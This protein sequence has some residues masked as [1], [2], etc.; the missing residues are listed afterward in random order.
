MS[1]ESKPRIRIA[2][3]IIEDGKI[4]LVKGRGYEYIWTPGGKLEE[5]ETDEECLKRE[6]KEEIGVDLIEAKF[7]REYPGFSF[8][9][10]AKKMDQRVYL[11]KIKGDIKPDME[12]ENFLWFSKEDFYNKKYPILETHEGIFLADLIKERIW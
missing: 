6:L 9:N 5:G 8:F 10:P 1:D 3:I 2:A 12:I 7:F 11:I 4:L